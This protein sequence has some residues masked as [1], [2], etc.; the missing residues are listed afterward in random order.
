[1]ANIIQKILGGGKDP[2]V[3]YVKSEFTRYEQ[4]H[5]PRFSKAEKVYDSWTNKAPKRSFSWQNAVHVPLMV[6]GEQ[7]ITPRLFTALF[8]TDAPLDVVVEGDTPEEQGIRIKGLLQHFFRVADVQGE[9]LPMLGQTTLFGTGYIEGGTWLVRKGWQISDKGERYYTPIESRPDAKFIS[10]FEMYPHPAKLRMDDGLPLIRRRFC[11]AEF[12]K[13]L[14][15]NPNWNTD[16]I[17]KALNSKP[18]FAT[19]DLGKAYQVK[20]WDEYEIVEYYG[21]WDESYE[22]NGNVVTKKA[23]PYHIIMINRQVKIRGIPNPYNHQLPPFCKTKLFVDAKPSWFGVGIG[24]IGQSTQERV[25]K[26][27]NQRLDNVDL[28]LN[29]QGCYNGNDPLINTKKLG[30]SQPGKWHKVSDTVTSLRWM[31]IPDVTQSSYKEEEIA[32]NDFR[33]ATGATAHL[34]P[35]EQGAHRTAMGIQM[36]QGAAG[37]RFRPVLR[38]MEIDFIQQIAMFFFSNLKQF[39]TDEE[40]VMITGKSGQMEPI[41]ITPEEIQAKVFFIPTGVSE[42]MNKEVQVG[43][44][45][46]FKEVTMQDPTVNRQELNKRIA[47]LMGFKDIQK[48]LV[49]QQQSSQ[50]GLGPEDQQRIQ[51]RLAEGAN[52]EAIK[53]EM[54]GPHPQGEGQQGGQA[55][56]QQPAG[57]GA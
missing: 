57:A 24:Q 12:L 2:M 49:P 3:E 34:M 16:D 15:D 8:P 55:Q 46:R 19:K 53:E 18:T 33:E 41:K 25:N 4:F 38:K 21:P 1:M 13:N 36:L 50:N 39:M 28:V 27:V 10:F 43:Q 20:P 14:K 31:E 45:L 26:I 37:M 9:A 32:K 51:Q 11:D 6:E 40:W 7:T 44:L 48:L 23:I 52:P 30:I 22:N 56:S 35:G 47:E 17:D 42:T 54:L 29:K 5:S